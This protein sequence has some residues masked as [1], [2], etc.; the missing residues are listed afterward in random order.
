[1]FARRLLPAKKRF[2]FAADIA[3]CFIYAVMVIEM[4]ALLAFIW[5]VRK[6]HFSI[7]VSR[8]IV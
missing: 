1:M 4:I 6:F 5:K 7:S 3:V 8:P 2:D